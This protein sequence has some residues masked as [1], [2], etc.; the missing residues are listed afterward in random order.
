MVN[1]ET[2]VN[3]NKPATFIAG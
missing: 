3:S 1:L 2:S